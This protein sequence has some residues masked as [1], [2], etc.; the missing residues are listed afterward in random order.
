MQSEESRGFCFKNV[1]QELRDRHKGLPKSSLTQRWLILCIFTNELCVDLNFLLLEE[2]SQMPWLNWAAAK[3][4][5]QI[6]EA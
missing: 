2:I 1:W 6:I 5:K 4:D 3:C